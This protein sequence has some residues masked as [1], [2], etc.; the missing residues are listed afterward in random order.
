MAKT[1]DS[2]IQFIEA[3]LFNFAHQIG[4]TAGNTTLRRYAVLIFDGLARGYT[5]QVV[6]AAREYW[7]IDYSCHQ[8]KDGQGASDG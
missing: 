8:K 7:D 1:R 2:T 5:D 4:S 6:E 3:A